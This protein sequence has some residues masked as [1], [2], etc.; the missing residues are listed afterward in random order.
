MKGAKATARYISGITLDELQKERTQVLGTTPEDIRGY[1]KMLKDAMEEN[2][3]C[4]LGNEDKIRHNK[5]HFKDF[6][7]VFQ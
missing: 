4:V 6:I 2:Y 3:L 7:R 1:S 5:E